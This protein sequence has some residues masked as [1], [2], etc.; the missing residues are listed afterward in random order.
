[1]VRGWQIAPWLAAVLSWCLVNALP[2]RSTTKDVELRLVTRQASQLTPSDPSP[3][4]ILRTQLTNPVGILAV[5]LI[6]GGDVIQQACA[7]L[8][9]GLRFP[10]G[11]K[12]T[13]Q[14]RHYFSFTPV[15]F[16]FGWVAYAFKALSGAFGD[17]HLMPQ[18][19]VPGLVLTVGGQWKNNESWIIGR[20]LRDLELEN[21]RK[22][23]GGLKID[24][25]RSCRGAGEPNRDR[26]WWF[27]LF[28]FGAQF[29]VA[30]VPVII[31]PGRRNW[32]ILL[33]TG[34]G[35]GLALVAGCMPQWG[36]EKY[37]GRRVTKPTT[38]VLTRGNGH[39]HV[40]V[41]M[42]DKDH[43]FKNLDDLATTRPIDNTLT[44]LMSIILAVFWLFLLTLVG[45]L[46]EDGWFL[47]LVGLI[48]MVSNVV[49]ANRPRSPASHGLPI[50]R[51]TQ[52]EVVEKKRVFKALYTVEF[53]RDPAPQGIGNALQ[54]IFL[55]AGFLNDQKVVWERKTKKRQ[56]KAAQEKS[57]GKG[58]GTSRSIAPGDERRERKQQRSSDHNSDKSR[59]S[60]GSSSGGNG[61]GFGGIGRPQ[62]NSFKRN[63]KR[64]PSPLTQPAKIG[65]TTTVGSSVQIS[66]QSS[67]RRRVKSVVARRIIQP[68]DAG[69][70][71]RSGSTRIGKTERT[72]H[73][74]SQ[75]SQTDHLTSKQR[76]IL[77]SK[78][79]RDS[80]NGSVYFK[81]KKPAST[82]VGKAFE[83]LFPHGALIMPTK[84]E[85]LQCG[86]YA[87]IESLRSMYEQGI[88][89][90]P[91][92]P[93]LKAL[94]EV[95]NNNYIQKHFGT[96]LLDGEKLN[97]NNW[98]ADQVA[99]IAL[100]WGL[101][102]H[103]VSLQ[104][105]V[106]IEGE[107]PFLASPPP[108]VDE[109]EA[110]SFKSV[111]FFIHNNEGTHRGSLNH[112]SGLKPRI[113]EQVLEA[114]SDEGSK[115]TD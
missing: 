42:V 1:M 77:E 2:Q 78:I 37:T 30:S 55:P 73:S 67:S 112:Y 61:G 87:I 92:P 29:A 111:T 38:Y 10:Y 83:M 57:D 71:A 27:F 64:T 59:G 9:S 114:E 72:F 85:G 4:S 56:K 99:A 63:G 54:P 17:G 108:D 89:E 41:I 52:L 44:K 45:G 113:V 35:T 22:D 105:G 33:I 69:D 13:S 25:Y 88:E 62:P 106:I 43:N 79:I 60:S 82:S 23:K 103:A 94:E 16:S 40:F 96:M 66:S 12:N 115:E 58:I 75:G 39:S 6:I 8:V 76:A 109:F 101:S 100:Y 47:L 21:P 102:A 34:I 51:D 46:E 20:L 28:A 14:E 5:L 7:Q 74:A 110:T 81:L 26:V 90:V 11:S 80:A 86:L 24:F 19:D 95:A 84:D 49:V 15:A 91:E 93:T 98:S 32:T 50:E 36:E 3:A 48:G 31:H 104:M 97:T 107:P 68:P 53:K 65:E 18:T 70:L